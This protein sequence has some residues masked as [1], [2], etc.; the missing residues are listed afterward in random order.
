MK[1]KPF[2]L[3]LVG[4][5]ASGKG[6]QGA[7]LAKHYHLHNFDMGKEVRRPAIR[8]R[9]NYRKTVAMGNLTPTKVCR[10]ILRKVIRAVPARQGILFNGHP[11]M[12]GEAKLTARLLQHYRRSDP[13]V[14]YL[15]IPISE[16]MR[17]AGKR[18][19]EDDTLRGLRNRKRYYKKEISRV[20]AFFK[21]KYV[22]KNISGMGTREEVYRRITA[23]IKQNA[24]H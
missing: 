24:W 5:P 18:K 17:R 10:D 9:Y 14:I 2:N 7:R 19:R 20:V 21:K 11:K 13:F 6:V 12:L 1:Q 15:S 4:D 8:A 22:L 3:V 23:A 16:T